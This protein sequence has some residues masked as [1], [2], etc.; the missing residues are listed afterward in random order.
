MSTADQARAI[1]AVRLAGEIATDRTIAIVYAALDSKDATVRYAA[2]SALGR[3]LRTYGLPGLAL[4]PQQGDEAITRLSNLL[5][6]ETD[7]KVLDAIVRSLATVAALQG[8]P[9]AADELSLKAIRALC[10]GITAR[11]VA[12]D[13]NAAGDDLT[14]VFV[15]AGEAM[16]FEFGARFE[17]GVSPGGEVL[18]SAAKFG[19]QLIAHIARGVAVQTYPVIVRTDNDAA[20]AAKV[21]ARLLISQQVGVGERVLEFARAISAGDANP[22]GTGLADKVATAQPADDGA[23][24]EGARALLGPSSAAGAIVRAD[25]PA[26]GGRGSDADRHGGRA[27][28]RPAAAPRGLHLH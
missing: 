7:P 20:K 23:F 15:R 16:S 24:V 9:S 1:N 3:A 10:D 4:G 12:L 14:R 19:G 28:V 25:V 5:K 6:K 17:S 22:Q 8:P 27:G 11:L 21:E 26:P 2:C 18:A 13:K